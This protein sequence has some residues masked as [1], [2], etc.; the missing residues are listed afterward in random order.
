MKLYVK[1][2]VSIRC[3]MVVKEELKKLGLHYVIVDL[4]EIEILEDLSKSQREQL[5]FG[6]QKSGLELM[7]DKKAILIEKI[8]NVIVEMVHYSEAP[9]KVNFSIFLAEK[10]QHDYTYLSNLFSEVV[11]TT[12]EHYIIAH[13]IE[14]VKELIVY[15]ELNLTEISY[16]LN[17]SSVAHLSTQFKKVTGLTPSHF[18]KLKQKRLGGLDEV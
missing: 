4:G 16:L 14:R 10:L 3:K 2:M 7:D 17:Y 18:K 1:F 13:K 15:D 11:G 8:K 9:P 6:L 12:I 5:K